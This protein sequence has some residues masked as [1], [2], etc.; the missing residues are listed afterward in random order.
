MEVTFSGNTSAQTYVDL[1]LI[2]YK[3]YAAYLDGTVLKTGDGILRGDVKIDGKTFSAS[4]GSALRVYLGNTQSGTV[5]VRYEGTA[6]QKISK[7]VTLFTL[8]AAA[9]VFIRKKV[10]SKSQARTPAQ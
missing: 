10:R 8:L 5:T 6:V 9:G 1:P 2:N 4:Y 7:L 3:G